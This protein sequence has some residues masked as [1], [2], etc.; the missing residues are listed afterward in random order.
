MSVTAVTTITLL[1]M[2]TGPNLSRARAPG[3]EDRCGFRDE[4]MPLG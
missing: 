1:L 3:I 4:F 2:A